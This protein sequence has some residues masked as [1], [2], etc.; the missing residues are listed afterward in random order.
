MMKNKILVVDDD[1]KAL[2]LIEAMLIPA[3]YYVVTLADS[4]RVINIAREMKPDLIL[5]DIMMPL[6][7]GYTILNKLKR[8]LNRSNIPIVM[9]SAVAD[10]GHKVIAGMD[11]ASAYITKPI[12]KKALLETV[13]HFLPDSE[14]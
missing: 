12:D 6:E 1:P 7:D 3:G 10:D 2:E 13:A 5:L 14:S 9:V 8:G 11:G 4:T